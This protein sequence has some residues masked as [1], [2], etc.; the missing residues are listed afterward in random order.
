MP[1]DI[2]K[3]ANKI[4]LLEPLPEEIQET[5]L[6]IVVLPKTTPSDAAFDPL[7]PY[8]VR[9]VACPNMNTKLWG[10]IP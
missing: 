10:F 1:K 8:Q 9:D 4:M 3:I 7:T 5:E 6:N 2:T